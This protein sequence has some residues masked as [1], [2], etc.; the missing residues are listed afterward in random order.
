M[1]VP[2]APERAATNESTETPERADK[3]ERTEFEERT[4]L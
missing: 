1:R 3:L 4:I 2:C